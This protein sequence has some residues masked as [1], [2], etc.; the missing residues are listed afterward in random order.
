MMVWL[1][2]WPHLVYKV[3]N[4]KCD[5]SGIINHH[6]FEPLS[7]PTPKVQSWLRHF[8][9][10]ERF[11]RSHIYWL[12]ILE[13]LG[14]WVA[15]TLPRV[16]N[17]LLSQDSC[18]TLFKSF[19]NLFQLGVLI[20]SLLLKCLTYSQTRLLDS[21]FDSSQ[22]TATSTSPWKAGLWASFTC[23]RSRKASRRKFIFLNDYQQE[24]CWGWYWTTIGRHG[25]KFERYGTLTQ[26]KCQPSNPPSVDFRCHSPRQLVYDW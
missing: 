21:L 24:E 18:S 13:F 26:G 5:Y 8:L 12:L 4:R 15:G 17:H 2:I 7:T 9:P 3:S 16:F 22:A 1:Y 20:G 19:C 25:C 23:T 6:R 11:V 14:H 10:N